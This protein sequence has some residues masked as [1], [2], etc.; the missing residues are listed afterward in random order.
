[1]KKP[2]LLL[3]ASARWISR[4]TFRLNNLLMGTSAKGRNQ[5]ELPESQAIE[6]CADAIGEVVMFVM[7]GGLVVAVN[8]HDAY[9]TEQEEKEIMQKI[10]Q[11]QEVRV[12]TPDWR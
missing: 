3:I 10:S 4:S 1:M 7:V 8:Q 5:F 11:I 12:L 2:I 9:E 6:R